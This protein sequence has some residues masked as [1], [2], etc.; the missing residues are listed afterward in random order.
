MFCRKRF[1][2][3]PDTL[4]QGRG[5]IA[6]L[7]VPSIHRVTARWKPYILTSCPR[8]SIPT[9]SINVVQDRKAYIPCRAGHESQ[10]D[11]C[12]SLFYRSC[13][14][15]GAVPDCLCV[16]SV[17]QHVAEPLPLNP[18]RAGQGF[19]WSLARQDKLPLALN[20]RLRDDYSNAFAVLLRHRNELVVIVLDVRYRAV[21]EAHP[22][23]D[24]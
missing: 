23:P 8:T 19:Q 2:L 21:I 12:A 16:I 11:A 18:Y 22:R 14:L 1:V 20:R 6:R 13:Q 17:G 3:A 15:D 24:A 4:C 9:Y 10:S 5:G 7:L